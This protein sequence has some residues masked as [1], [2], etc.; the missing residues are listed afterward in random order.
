LFLDNETQK[1]ISKYF[2][3]KEFN[4]SPYPGSYGQQPK[5]WVDRYYIIKSALTKKEEL[6]AKK[7]RAKHGEQ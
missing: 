3:C 6:M 4:I 2:Y 7:E 5:K 1:D